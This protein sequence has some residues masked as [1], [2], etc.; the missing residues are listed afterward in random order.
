M[1]GAKSELEAENPTS[2]SQSFVDYK[3]AHMK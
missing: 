3:K 2:L 1:E